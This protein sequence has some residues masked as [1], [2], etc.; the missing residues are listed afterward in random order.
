MNRPRRN[1]PGFTL[2][3]LLLAMSMAAMLMMSLYL[4]MSIGMRARNSVAASIEPVR[5]VTIAM[6]L[7]KQDLQ[8]VVPPASSSSTTATLAGP[9]FG[10][11][12]LN[13]DA[14]ADWVSFYCIGSDSPHQ[15][16]PLSEGIRR[17]ELGLRTD[18]N[19]PALVRRITRNLMPFVQTDPE[20]EVLCRNVRALKLR[21]F[22]GSMWQDEWDSTLVGDV[23]PMSVEITIEMADPANR[24]DTPRTRTVAVV[25]LAC[26]KPVDLTTQGGIVP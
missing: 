13:A 5:A 7:V 25:P 24:T 11:Q 12:Q 2:I 9:F 16:Q 18:V 3:E 26:A 20:E 4:A 23:L 10:V 19:P 6:D 15:D 14:E 8:S 22:D 17:I 1:A 21:Y